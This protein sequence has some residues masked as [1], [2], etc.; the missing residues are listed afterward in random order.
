[1]ITGFPNYPY[2]E[3]YPGY[4]RTWCQTDSDGKVQILRTWLTTIFPKRPIHRLANYLGFFISSMWAAMFYAKKQE[5]VVATSGPILVGFSGA[6]VSWMKR[7]PFILDLR[8]MWPERIVAAGEFKNRFALKILEW[9]EHFMYRRARRI[10][11][12]T[13]GLRENLIKKG[14]DERKICVIT[15]G[16][17]PDLFKPALREETS[18]FEAFGIPRGSFVVVYAGTLGLLQDHDM[19]LNTAEVLKE[20]KDIYLVLIG[21]GVRRTFLEEET[22]KRHLFNV[23]FLPNLKREQLAEILPFAQIGINPNTNIRHNRMAIPVKMF[24]YMACELP[25]VLAN[26][27]EV[28]NMVEDNL[29]GFCTLPGNVPMFVE[30]I[31]KLYRDQKL[32]L[33]MGKQGRKLVQRQFSIQLLSER[34]EDVVVNKGG[35][36]YASSI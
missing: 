16:T 5:I 34:F 12:V 31:L 35:R 15:N 30:A 29:I 27:G 1:M 22:I 3:I 2:R 36:T 13:E 18:V 21:E 20:F 24:D 10:V 19:I 14:V 6:L 7:I 25:V 28:K 11:C 8:D 4:K 26:D 17:D 23:R 32:R 33:E 9:I